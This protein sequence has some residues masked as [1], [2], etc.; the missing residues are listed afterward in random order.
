MSYL[1]WKLKSVTAMTKVIAQ[2]I[3]YLVRYDEQCCRCDLRHSNNF[4]D[5]LLLDCT[6][7]SGIRNAMYRKLLT[8]FGALFLQAIESL[9]KHELVHNLL[10]LWHPLVESV[11]RDSQCY[12]RFT[13]TVYRYIYEMYLKYPWLYQNVYT[14]IFILPPY[15]LK[16]V[17][18]YTYL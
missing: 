16:R 15:W 11:L 8:E 6:Y 18:M 1:P 9:P 12:N 5:H 10:G 3:A 2:L 13:C 14:Y 17:K 4:T 7:V